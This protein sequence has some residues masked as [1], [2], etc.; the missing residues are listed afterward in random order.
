MKFWQGQTLQWFEKNSVGGGM[1]PWMMDRNRQRWGEYRTVMKPWIWECMRRRLAVDGGSFGREMR[2]AKVFR[3]SALG[4]WW[5]LIYLIVDPLLIYVFVDL[6]FIFISDY[7]YANW[8][9]AN[10]F[11]LS[12]IYWLAYRVRFHVNQKLV[13]VII[14]FYYSP[15]V[16]L[17]SRNCFNGTQLFC[18]M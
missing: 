16:F 15:C 9:L 2:R 7:F 6:L 12:L 1:V 14:D 11:V 18:N 5:I 13:N 4:W 3:G 10:Y 17:T 8:L